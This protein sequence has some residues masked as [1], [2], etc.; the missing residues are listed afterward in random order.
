MIKLIIQSVKTDHRVD[1]HLPESLYPVVMTI[2]SRRPA[3]PRQANGS[4][5]ERDGKSSAPPCW[6]SSSTGSNYF[7]PRPSA[8]TTAPAR[9]GIGV[10]RQQPGADQR[11]L[12]NQCRRTTRRP[13]SA[14][15]T[16]PPT[17][18][19]R[20]TWSLPPPA[21]WT[22]TSAPRPRALQIARVAASRGLSEDKVKAGW[23]DSP[24]RRSGGSSARRE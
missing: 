18:S 5:V 8:C 20:R 24:S 11:R 22:R 17:P 1:P 4:L 23:S 3:F 13:S 16:C 14:A 12:A 21:A 9:P 7:W 10:Q 15:T 19:S 2:L 6:R